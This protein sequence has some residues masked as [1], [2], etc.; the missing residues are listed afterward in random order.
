MANPTRNLLLVLLGTVIGVTLTLGHAVLAQDESDEAAEDLPLEQLRTFTD[1][2]ER[3][4]DNYVEDVDDEELLEYAIEGML[5]GLDPHS[6]YLDKDA[7]EELQIGTQGEFGGLGIEV[8]MEDGFVRVVAPID[9]TPAA[10][11]GVKAGDVIVQL[12]DDPVKGMSLNDAVQKM[13]GEPGTEIKLTIAREGKDKPVELTIERDTIEVTSVDSRMLQPGYGYLRVSHFQNNTQEAVDKAIKDLK[14]EAEKEEE[15]L[16]GLV[17]DLRNNPGG[18]LSAAVSVSDTFL[19]EGL[20]VYTEGRIKD[21]KLRYSARPGD[22]IEDVPMVVLV[23]EGSASA[24]EIVAGALQDHERALVIG[25]KTFGKGSVQT[26]QD[27]SDGGA[28]KLT[29]ARYY[30]PDGRSIQAEGI[31][32]DIATGAYKL[33]AVEDGGEGALTEAD[34]SQH[35]TNP[36]GEDQVDMVEDED[37]EKV[38]LATSDYELYVGLNALKALSIFGSK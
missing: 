32:P 13:R 27:L 29:T 4:K 17:L 9:G 16:R 38:D 8:T 25:N 5:D 35:L 12:D 36:N 30:T 24:S 21:S 10:R 22:A 31:E 14:D 2:Y 23:N 15:G 33:T 18:V 20:I 6:S 7:F 3:I 34:L 28:L 37:G 26:I 19:E 1:V 11:A